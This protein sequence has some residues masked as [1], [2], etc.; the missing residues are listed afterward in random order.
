MVENMTEND[1]KNK[2]IAKTILI[3]LGGRRFATFTG[4]K[5]FGYIENGL[6]M[7]LPRNSSGANKLTITLTFMDDYT[8]TFEKVVLPRMRKDYT[9]T[10]GSK[11]TI[12]LIPGVFCDTLQEVFTET[13]G[14]YT[15]F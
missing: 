9:F 8:L 15:H 3:Q 11:K 12:K 5:D 4:A 13:T 7:K 2:E 6:T 10:T 14:L 1:I